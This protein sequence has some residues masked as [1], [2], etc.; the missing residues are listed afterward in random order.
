MADFLLSGNHD[1][2]SIAD[3]MTIQDIAGKLAAAGL[4]AV[5]LS[6]LESAALTNALRETNGNR[7]HAAKVLGIST[8]TLQRI[9]SR[10][11]VPELQD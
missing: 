10:G 1:P 3:G 2:L 9:L 4:R 7:T 6:D 8:R 11:E 5:R